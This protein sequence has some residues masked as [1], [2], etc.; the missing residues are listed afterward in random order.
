MDAVKFIQ[1]RNR[2][3]KSFGDECAGCPANDTIYRCKFSITV[4]DEAAKQV[5][6]LEE[7]SAAHPL[8][9][10]ADLFKKQYPNTEID[11]DGLPTLCPKC[12]DKDFNCPFNAFCQK[13][14]KEFWL[15]EVQNGR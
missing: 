12:I 8:I 14:R 1:E 3:C 11:T 5:K 10:R 13:C 7:W 2:M 6:L 9:T 15:K 4:G